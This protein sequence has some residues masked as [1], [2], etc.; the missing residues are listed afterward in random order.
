MKKERKEEIRE[1][2]ER[3]LVLWLENSSFD[4]MTIGGSYL[5]FT[6]G[7]GLLGGYPFKKEEWMG[8]D[9]FNSFIN[10]SEFNSTEYDDIMREIF[11]RELDKE[12]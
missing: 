2:V 11:N 7:I 5:R 1:E 6:I 10:M 12:S 4:D 8:K 9:D 3:R